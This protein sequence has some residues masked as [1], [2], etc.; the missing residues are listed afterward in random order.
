LAENAN[1]CIDSQFQ[2]LPN[3]DGDGFYLCVLSKN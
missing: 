3:V 1:W 2:L